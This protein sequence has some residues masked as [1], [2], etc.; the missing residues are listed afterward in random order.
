MSPIS[1]RSEL[2]LQPVME[3]DNNGEQYESSEGFSYDDVSNQQPDTHLRQTCRQRGGQ[4][5][6][7]MVSIVPVKDT[8][9]FKQTGS[10]GEKFDVPFVLHLWPSILLRNLLPYAVSYKLKVRC[11]IVY[12]PVVY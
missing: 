10:A 2:C 9:T 7:L 4:G 8:V 11:V 5:S 1:F 12:R 6:V 3:E